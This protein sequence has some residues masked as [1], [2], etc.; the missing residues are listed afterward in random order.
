MPWWHNTKAHHLTIQETMA[1]YKTTAPCNTRDA[2]MIQKYGTVRY[3]RRRHG[4]SSQE[5]TPQAVPAPGAAGA[6]VHNAPLH[7]TEHKFIMFS[8]SCTPIVEL[9]WVLLIRCRWCRHTKC[10]AGWDSAKQKWNCTWWYWCL[11][12]VSTYVTCQR[13]WTWNLLLFVWHDMVLVNLDICYSA[14]Y[15]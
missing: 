10:T 15:N 14:K 4:R 6:D 9:V 8:L 7:R 11:S 3:Q 12:W 5:S 2:G 1:G 13:A